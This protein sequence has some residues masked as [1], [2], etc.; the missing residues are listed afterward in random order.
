MA[1]ARGQKL[2]HHRTIVLWLDANL[3]ALTLVLVFIEP[4]FFGVRRQ[5]RPCF[6]PGLEAEIP[7]LE[8]RKWHRKHDSQA[9]AY[10][11]SL[12]SSK[13]AP[14]VTGLQNSNVAA[15]LVRVRVIS[16]S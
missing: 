3:P 4:P 10:C 6:L 11:N 5:N 2:R 14:K 12:S 9:T 16:T 1:K 8:Y 13:N 7:H 15:S